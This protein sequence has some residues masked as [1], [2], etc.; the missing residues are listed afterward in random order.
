MNPRP[1]IVD[2]ETIGLRTRFE[3]VLGSFPEVRDWLRKSPECAMLADFHINHLGIM[4]ARSP[5]E[6]VRVDQSGTF[7]LACLEG[8]GVVRVDGAWKAIRAGQACLLPPFVMNAL[9]CR[10]DGRWRFAWVRYG[11]SRRAKP[12]VSSISPVIGAFAGGG[13]EAAIK[14]LRAEVC[15]QNNP[16]A[17]HQWCTLVHHYVL[18]F[19]EPAHRDERLWRLW[20]QV[21]RDLARDW[22][23]EQLA[24]VACLSCEHLRRLC[25]REIGRSPMRH[26]TFIRLQQ[27]VQLLTTTDDKLATIARAV[28]FS[29]VHGF[30][31]AFKM[32]F[33]RAPSAF[34]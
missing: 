26:L 10:G 21:E 19:A 27:A 6:V 20:N 12:I 23:L 9:K 14:G 24:A 17:L 31:H 29:G 3:A 2:R 5:Y 4:D 11:E 18:Q 15:S 34:R 30:S 8:E 22:T 7:M 16:A 25:L 1:P 28:G 32:R 13:I 33:G